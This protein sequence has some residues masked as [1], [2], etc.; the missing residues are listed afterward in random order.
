MGPPGWVAGA[1]CLV[2]CQPSAGQHIMCVVQAAG[3]QLVCCVP[4]SQLRAASDL[5]SGA[6]E[7]PT[8]LVCLR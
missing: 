8:S 1:A 6:G 3:H 5:A 4:P 2:S 7:S